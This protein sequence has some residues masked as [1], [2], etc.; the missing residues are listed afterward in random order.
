MIRGTTL[1]G[2]LALGLAGFNLLHY[3]RYRQGRRDQRHA[4]QTWEAEGGA[5]PTGPSTT[6]AQVTPEPL[7]DALQR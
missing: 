2:L 1:I 6:A 7:P 5:V 4:L 3:A